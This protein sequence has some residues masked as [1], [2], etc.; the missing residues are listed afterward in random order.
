M[1]VSCPECQGKVS[2]E[3]DTCPHCG[4]RMNRKP[5]AEPKPS[6]PQFL[7]EVADRRPCPYCRHLVKVEAHRCTACLKE[8]AGVL[9]VVCPKCGR[10]GRVGKETGQTA[11]DACHFEF[12]VVAGA[13]AAVR[14]AVQANHRFVANAE[15]WRRMTQWAGSLCPRCGTR[16]ISQL[17]LTGM[18]VGEVILGGLLGNPNLA[19]AP[20][21]NA[22][23]RFRCN[24]CGLIWRV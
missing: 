11:C 21:G 8:I 1:L 15:A 7:A 6:L 16:N 24:Q 22:S 5:E 12:N 3:A 20:L 9:R 4:Y 17:G 13:L 10:H 18:D 2:T 19:V 23:N 14:E